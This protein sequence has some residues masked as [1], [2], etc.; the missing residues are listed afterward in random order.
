MRRTIWTARTLANELWWVRIRIPGRG[1]CQKAPNGSRLFELQASKKDDVE[2]V[3]KFF[4][5]WHTSTGADLR[6]HKVRQIFSGPM[7]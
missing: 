3:L 1:K 5:S 7:M 4:D 6:R 2:Q